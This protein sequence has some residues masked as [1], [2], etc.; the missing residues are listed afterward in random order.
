MTPGKAG[1]L[2]RGRKIQQEADVNLLAKYPALT[3]EQLALARQIRADG[4]Q[5][6]YRAA[7]R[8]DEQRAG[9]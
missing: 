6:G 3:P 7:T 2:K 8:R 1:G 4:Y 9:A 5:A